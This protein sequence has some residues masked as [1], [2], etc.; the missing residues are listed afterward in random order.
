M[1]Q[2]D[3]LLL[4]RSGS[5]GGTMWTEAINAIN[6]YVQKLAD[7]DIDTGVT[8]VVFDSN[9]PFEVIRDRITPK[10][11]K[12]IS[13]DEV[14]PRGGTPLN[15]ATASLITLA[16]KGPPWG[17]QYDK[18]AIVIMT[19]GEENSSQEYDRKKGGT[20]KIK[21]K[22]DGCRERGW[23]VTM[24]GAGFDNQQQAAHYGTATRSTVQ[25]SAKNFGDT[26]TLM[27]SKRGLY[28]SA[29]ASS[30][31]MDFS[32]DEQEALKSDTKADLKIKTT[33]K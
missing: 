15:D 13:N 14:S 32:P 9:N 24:L 28:A 21:A 26:M 17:G 12:P 18:V 8:L 16:E 10:T 19:D 7:D 29:G 31:T 30:A 3:F 6:A 1:A 33:T 20:E 25:T 5:M 4:D 22:L 11:W 23:A 2:H 27:A